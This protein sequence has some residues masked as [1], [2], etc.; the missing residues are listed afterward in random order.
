MA[1]YWRIG[2]GAAVVAVVSRGSDGLAHEPP[3]GRVRP[4]LLTTCQLIGSLPWRGS[5]EARSQSGPE[6]RHAPAVTCVAGGLVKW[7][8]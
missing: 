4:G 3:A 1:S 8:Q 5:K 2:A 6:I 7:W